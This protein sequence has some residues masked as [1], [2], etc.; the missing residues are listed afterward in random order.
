MNL[1]CF[2]VEIQ[3][4]DEEVSLILID[5]SHSALDIKRLTCSPD[6]SLFDILG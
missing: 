3:E 5:N 2:L 4:E 6:E 1:T